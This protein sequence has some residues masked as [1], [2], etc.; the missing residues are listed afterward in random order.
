MVD[1]L[2]L[3]VPAT[4][5]TTTCR[6]PSL[7]KRQRQTLENVFN[8][9]C[10]R[11]IDGKKLTKVRHVDVMVPVGGSAQSVATPGDGRVEL[12]ADEYEHNFGNGDERRELSITVVNRSQCP[13]YIEWLTRLRLFPRRRGD[14]GNELAPRS[15]D[16]TPRR[17]WVEGANACE[18]DDLE[19]SP[20][21]ALAVRLIITAFGYC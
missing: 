4:L 10:K 14:P 12:H 18:I 19:P 7:V 13:L 9:I 6:T 11:E 8:L 16:A 17:N 3:E 15:L 20:H 21:V 1:D 5:T 2:P